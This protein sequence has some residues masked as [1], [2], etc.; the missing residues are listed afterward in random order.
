MSD[1]E[2]GAPHPMDVALGARIRLLRENAKL[3]R[4]TMAAELDVSHR[5]IEKY[6]NGV[7]RVS[8]SRLTEIAAVLHMTPVELI[9][10][11]SGAPAAVKKIIEYTH[12]LQLPGAMELL[13]AYSRLDTNVRKLALK[14]VRQLGGK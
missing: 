3:S 8:W 6:E 13:L 7:N 1:G 9:Q 4:E 14:L 5:A 2:R 12:I 10:P 11:L